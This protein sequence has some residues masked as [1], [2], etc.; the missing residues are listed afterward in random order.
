MVVKMKTLTIGIIFLF[1]ISALAPLSMG[2]NVKTSIIENNGNTI[3]FMKTF[4]G[5]YHDG[6]HSVQQTTDNGYIIT[7]CTES[8][9]ADGSF[10]VWL[11]KTDKDGKPRNKAVTNIHMF[12]LRF[13]K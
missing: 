8:F 2:Y 13:L 10:D 6:G 12:L 1:I 9:G 7:G 4:G 5:L 11:I 3:T